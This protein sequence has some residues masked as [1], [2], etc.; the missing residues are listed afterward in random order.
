MENLQAIVD[1]IVAAIPT[2]LTIIGAFAVIATATPNKVDDKILQFI[3][4]LI[5]FLGANLGK[6][7]NDA[8]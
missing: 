2:V 7:K 4:D 3:M 1:Q 5:N 6:A 8:R